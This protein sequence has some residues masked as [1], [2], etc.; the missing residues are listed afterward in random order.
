MHPN[1]VAQ[2][3]SSPTNLLQVPGS[4]LR[5]LCSYGGHI[6]P[7]DNSLY[8]VGG[9]TRIVAMDR[10][11]S[12]T[13]LCSHLSRNLLH[14]RRSFTLKYHLPDEDLDNLITVSTDED[15]QNM[16]EEYDRLS[17]NP[18]PS[19][20]RLRLFLFFSKPETAVS[21]D[22]LHYDDSNHSWFVEALNN[23]GILS[24]VVSDSAAVVDNCLLNI[25]DYD[26]SASSCNDENTNNNVNKEHLIDVDYSAP[27]DEEDNMF[28]YSFDNLPQI[29]VRID[30]QKLVD[31]EQQQQQE[32][33]N[34]DD[35]KMANVKQD[36]AFH[37]QSQVKSDQNQQ[38]EQVNNSTYTS[39]QQLDQNPQ[40]PAT[41]QNQFVYIHRPIGTGQ[42]PISSYY[43]YYAPQSHQQLNQFPIYVMPIGLGSTQP[44]NMAL[45]PNI[46]DTNVVASVRPQIPQSVVSEVTPSVYKA[47][48]ASNSGFIQIPSNQFQQQ[49]VNLPQNIHHPPHPIYGYDYGGA[50]Q[51]QIYYTQTQQQHANANAP[52]QYQSMTPAVAG[53]A[54]SDVSKQFP[55]DKIQQL[56]KNSQQV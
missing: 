20:S 45:Q 7:R 42:V 29:R 10:H 46:A 51:E 17:S 30:E 23:S 49:Y 3:V 31:M 34:F 33:N 48:V 24:R 44:Y 28:N 15:L 9:D 1:L 32:D 36:D 47:P 16:I 19:P 2:V 56:N 37:V 52:S 53:A 55:T 18:S 22:T 26:A 43:P 5:L 40:Q 6:M 35:V 41:Y 38:G 11:S 27:V 14:G 39:A 13:H 8:Y 12:L 25:D 21:M 54:I 50:M 4:K